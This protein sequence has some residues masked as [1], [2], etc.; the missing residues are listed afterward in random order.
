VPVV[1]QLAQQAPAQLAQQAP[2]Q[3]AL[4]AV[5]LAQQVLAAVRP[6]RVVARPVSAAPSLL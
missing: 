3:L 5:P 2:A 6:A 1:G 4:A